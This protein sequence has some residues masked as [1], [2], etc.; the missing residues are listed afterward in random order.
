MQGSET[1]RVT[2]E[3]AQA[4]LSGLI[5]AASKGEFVTITRYGEPVAALMSLAASE[6]A[7][8]EIKRKRSGLVAY[9]RNFPGGD[10]ERNPAR[11]RDIET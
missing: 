9:L 8:R 11:S 1:R 7:R 10:F 3:E 4:E 5:D 2:L 6:I